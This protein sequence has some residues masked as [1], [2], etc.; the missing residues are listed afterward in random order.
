MITNGS[1]KAYPLPSL[2]CHLLFPSSSGIDDDDSGVNNFDHI[3]DGD[4][5]LSKGNY[6]KNERDDDNQLNEIFN[7][8]EGEKKNNGIPN[9]WDCISIHNTHC[10]IYISKRELRA[11]N[12]GFSRREHFTVIRLPLG[13][14]KN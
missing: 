14:R 7:C 4:D 12:I 10:S 3:E 8:G 11:W 6:E 1:F 9:H 5:D 2:A 13:S